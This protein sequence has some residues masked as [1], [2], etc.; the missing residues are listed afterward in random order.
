MDAQRQTVAVSN[1]RSLMSRN[2]PQQHGTDGSAVSRNDSVK[3]AARTLQVFE[4]FADCQQPLSLSELARRI[5]MPVSSSHALLKTLQNFGYVYVLEQRKLVYPTKRLLQVA[6]AIA[7]RD[8]L[9][10]TL[11]P[12]INQLRDELGETVIVGK[13]QTASVVYLE[14][15]EGTHTVR[16]AARPGDTKPL[17]SSAIGKAMLGQLTPDA[18]LTLL[19]RSSLPAVTGRT[20]TDRAALIDEINRSR[21][22]GWYMTCGENVDDVAAIAVASEVYGETVGLAVAGP[23]NRMTRELDRYTSALRAYG[24]RLQES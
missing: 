22:R 24:D 2:Q 1:Q 7:V 18:L 10:E 12:I 11:A 8:P 3:T 23:A 9:L 13:R 17:H 20:I 16:Y 19:K 4:T 21:E 6:E 5:D 14:V 15:I